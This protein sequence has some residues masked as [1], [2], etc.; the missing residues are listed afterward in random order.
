ME[1]DMSNMPLLITIGL[2]FCGYIVAFLNG[3]HVAKRK[4]RLELLNKQMANFYGP[5]YVAS[6]VGR[7]AVT[8]FFTSIGIKLDIDK[9][10]PLKNPLTKEQE[11]EYRIWVENV[12]MPINDWCEKL[13]RENAHLIREK[14]MP[15]CILDFFGHVSVYRAVIAKWEKKDFSQIYS[16]IPFPNEL[17]SYAT[18]SYNELKDEQLGLINSL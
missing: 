9:D 16:A 5:L 11:V 6:H 14:R 18:K 13:M 4:D 8:A 2:A 3:A 17:H 15:K 10:L 12:L 7:A 1:S